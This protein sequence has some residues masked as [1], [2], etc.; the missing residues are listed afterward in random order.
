MACCRV[1]WICGSCLHKSHSSQVAGCK[2]APL[3]GSRNPSGES[4]MV[5]KKSKASRPFDAGVYLETAGVKRKIVRCHKGQAFFRKVRCPT[6]FT[7]CNPA[8][9][10]SAGKEAVIA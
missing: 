2:R 4:R 6:Q 3:I 5:K 9:T 10:S 8:P 1:G 7:I